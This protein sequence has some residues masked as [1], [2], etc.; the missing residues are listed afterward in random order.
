LNSRQI[1]SV[2]PFC[3]FVIVNNIR[4]CW[5]LI[6]RRHHHTSIDN[7][8]SSTYNNFAAFRIALIYPVSL[9]WL[10]RPFLSPILIGSICVAGRPPIHRRG[11]RIKDA[12]GNRRITSNS[13]IDI[14]EP[15]CRLV[16]V[17]EMDSRSSEFGN[18]DR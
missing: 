17:L 18:P 14:G 9:L 16:R 13:F 11:A 3:D 12:H 2:V 15:K 5:I 6:C 1:C 8:N 4:N 7:S 10:G